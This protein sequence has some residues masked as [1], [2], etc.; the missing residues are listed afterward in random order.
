MQGGSF[1][2]SETEAVLRSV[3][4]YQVHGARFFDIGFSFTVDPPESLRR[5]RISDNLIYANP[6]PGDRV[7]VQVLMGNVSRVSLQEGE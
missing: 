5:A 7:L 6:R 3:K 2:Q 4:P 1:F